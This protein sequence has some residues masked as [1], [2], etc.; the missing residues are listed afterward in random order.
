M[1]NNSNPDQTTTPKLAPDFTHRLSVF[2]NEATPHSVSAAVDTL[3]RQ[4]T[5]ILSLVSGEFITGD[6]E[7]NC[8]IPDE[9]V[10][11][12]LDAVRMTL[13]DVNPIVMAHLIAEQAKTEANQRLNG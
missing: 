3:T 8:P 12:A 1:K 7:R 10:F 6:E 13:A 4:A 2:G 11:W 9:D 5:A